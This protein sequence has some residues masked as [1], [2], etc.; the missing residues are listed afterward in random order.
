MDTSRLSR[1]RDLQ[2]HQV[3]VALRNGSRL[4]DCQLVS[5]GRKRA[6]SIWLVNAGVDTF[7]PAVD[8]VELWEAASG[9]VRAA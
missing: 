9:H 8:I 5:V 7:V 2:G 4:D 1:L 3:S 6:P